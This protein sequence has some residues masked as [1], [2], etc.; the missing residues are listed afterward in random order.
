MVD[1]FSHVIQFKG[2]HYNFGMMQGE[3]LKNSPIIVNRNKYVFSKRKRNY[4]INE[5]IYKEIINT[6]LPSMWDEI[7]GLADALE[8]SI[9]QAIEQFGGY[10]LEYRRSGCSVFTSEDYLVRNYDFHPRSYDGRFLLYKP[11]D[12]GYASIGPSM[13]ITG[14]TDGI[15]EKGLAMGYNF[16]NRRNSRDGFLCNMIGRIILETCATIEEAIDLL[17]DIPHRNSFSYV[18]LDQSGMSRVVEASPRKVTVR[19]ANV[20][21]NHFETLTDENRFHTKDSMRRIDLISKKEPLILNSYD[22]FKMMNNIEEN[23]FGTNYQSS[24]GTLHTS[25]YYPQALKA[26]ISLGANRPP[27]M[28]DFGKWLKGERLT[29]TKLKGQLDSIYPFAN[30]I[31]PK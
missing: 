12:Q 18:L 14:R 17:K 11:T 8:M 9:L 19:D 24:S 4:I 1:V 6:F 13:Q 30:M 29:V 31:Q 20:C 25:I 27:F 22:A 28:F 2:T 5:D 3:R 7:N 16:V 10:Y 26:G 23:I 21:T 15:N